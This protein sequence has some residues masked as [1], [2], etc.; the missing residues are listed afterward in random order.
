[1]ETLPSLLLGKGMLFIVGTGP[2]SLEQMTGRAKEA[3]GLSTHIVGNGMYLDMLDDLVEGK[4]VVTSSM[5]REVDRARKAVELSSDNV[6][7]IVSGGDAGV[8]GMASIVLEIMER[9]NVEVDVEIVPGVTA[10]TA[11]AAKLGS[12]LSSD[13]MVI[14]LSDLL[15]PWEEI[16]RRL[17]AGFGLGVPVVLYNP[18][19]VRRPGNLARAVAIAVKHLPLTTPVGVVKDAYRPGEEVIITTL[20]AMQKDDSFVDMHSTVVVGGRDSRTWKVGSD[21]KGIITPRGYDR[22]YVY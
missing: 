18:K 14:S 10:A 2:G 17:E 22:K 11:A 4:Q 19:S 1:M 12:P 5:G 21:V 3:I 20:G 15:T 6:V 7:T 13:F 9:T 8:Y 16:D